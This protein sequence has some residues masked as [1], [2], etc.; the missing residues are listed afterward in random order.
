MSDPASKS[1]VVFGLAEEFLERHRR[2][3]RPSLKEYVDR[4]PELADQIREVFPAMAM[5]ESIA[6]ADESAGWP[7]TPGARAAAR[8]GD[9]EPGS[10]G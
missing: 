9:P 2:G 5:M 4:H 10:T 8:G 6:L 7:S 1:D 3:E